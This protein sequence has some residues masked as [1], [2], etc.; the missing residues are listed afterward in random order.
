[1]GI[2][3]LIYK[4]SSLGENKYGERS[5][6]AIQNILSSFLIKGLSILISFVLVPIS[7]NYLGKT[8]YG[9]WITLGSIINWFSYFDIGLGNG[10]RNK[11]A[12]SK[13]SGNL[14][15][16]KIYVS[17]TYF[18]LGFI[19]VSLILIFLIVSPFLNWNN[20]L[21]A[22]LNFDNSNELKIL[23]ISVFILFCGNFV[24]KLISTLLTANQQPAKASIFD[25][26]SRIIALILIYIGSYFSS[27]SI[28]FVGLTISGAQSIV[29]LC[30]NF[31]YFNRDFKDF[32][33]SFK[34]VK[35]EYSKDLFS[36]GIK[37][38]FIQLAAILLYQTN[39][40][41]ISQQLGPDIVTKYNIG[42]SYYGS[43]SMIFSII[44][45]PFWSAFTDAWV[46]KDFIWIKSI[47]SSLI[48][49]WIFLTILGI[50]M[51]IFSKQI[52]L[53]WIGNEIE[54][55]Y[56]LSI[57]MYL[58]F[59]ISAWNGVFS[60]LL[61]GIGK[62]KLQLWI[63]IVTAILNIPLS[64]Y[65]GTLFGLE[66]ILISNII[67]AV[68]GLFLYPIQYKKIINGNENGIWSA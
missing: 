65:F 63:G 57:I 60:T 31:F 52:F 10:L 28:I 22:G 5:S 43:L 1:M 12:E 49:S 27:G 47:I 21:N 23:A 11:F 4:I 34:F 19:M 13:S 66:G 58:Y 55:G 37:F 38:F 59:I 6:K 33:P 7:I 67:I 2:K 16:A 64:I 25:L 40:I 18:L 53:I 20:I 51:V 24:L 8:N 17:T 61:N 56:N 68:P 26:Y 35:F 14:K 62:V 54:I 15:L 9:I 45:S 50:L 48:K 41:I 3:N 32:K 39:V 30:A 46:K 44:I 42:F 36:L 29:L